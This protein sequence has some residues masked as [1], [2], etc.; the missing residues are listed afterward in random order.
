[1]GAPLRTSLASLATLVCALAPLVSGCKEKV[2]RAEMEKLV[3]ET[4]EEKGIKVKSVTCP[5]D[6]PRKVGDRFACDGELADGSKFVGNV[7]Q[8]EEGYKSSIVGRIMDLGLLAKELSDPKEDVKVE[9]PAKKL[10]LRKGDTF[11]CTVLIGAIHAEQTYRTTDD[12]GGVKVD[13]TAVIGLNT[14]KPERKDPLEADYEVAEDREDPA[15]CAE[16]TPLAKAPIRS[17]RVEGGRSL[18]GAALFVKGCA[19]EPCEWE[20]IGLVNTPGDDGWRRDDGS[21]TGTFDDKCDLIART[22]AT[23]KRTADGGVRYE[24]RRLEL[25]AALMPKACPDPVPDALVA[26]MRCVRTRVIVATA[27]KKP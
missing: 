26:K 1:M 21:E 27:K 25:P 19:K 20:T 7:T 16:P 3:R 13:G 10:L 2:D 12:E 23:L 18:S 9:C 6:R 15:G 4:L 14:S 22:T 17:L 24:E 5:A 11:K 8:T